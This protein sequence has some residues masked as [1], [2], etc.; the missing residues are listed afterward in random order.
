[1]DNEHNVYPDFVPNQVLTN[2]QL[3]QLRQY[4][5][6][7]NRLGRVRLTGTGIICGLNIHI[8]KNKV[9]I[10]D[11]FGISSEGY[12][13]ELDKAEKASSTFTHWKKYT[14]PNLQ[15]DGAI[16]YKSW[17]KTG[18]NKSQRHI[19]ELVTSPSGAKKITAQQLNGRVLV[20]Y[21]E[22]NNEQLDSCLVTDCD[23]KGVNVHFSIRVL[24][25]K[26]DALQAVKTC[27]SA[28][29]QLIHIPRLH[30]QL[31][32]T[33]V[34][35]PSQINA[36]Y[37]SIVGNM[38]KEVLT[39]LNES[40]NKY[41]AILSM[42]EDISKRLQNLKEVILKAPNQ[43]SWDILNDIADAYNEFISLACKLLDPCVEEQDFPRH[44]MLGALD[45]DAASY[46]QPFSPSRIRN[47]Q[48]NDLERVR[49]LFL[50][51]L[52]LANNID[53]EA[54]D[55]I[56][57]TPSHTKLYPLGKRAL[58][59][60]YTPEVEPYWQP[61]MC[62]TTEDVWSYHFQKKRDAFDYSKASLFRI[63]GHLGENCDDVTKRIR[64]LQKTFNLEFDLL[65]LGIS[66][67]GETESLPSI[68]NDI[69]G[70][71]HTAGVVKGGT[72][73]LLCDDNNTV[74]ADFS[75]TGQ[76]PCCRNF[77]PLELGSIRGQFTDERG[78][79]FVD[80]KVV[81]T[82]PDRSVSEKI[83]DAKAR[84]LFSN[85][86]TGV[87]T[88]Q[89]SI[90]KGQNEDFVSKPTSV[91]IAAGEDKVVNLVGLLVVTQK[92]IIK[93]RVMAEN[94][95]GGLAAPST[96]VPNAQVVLKPGNLKQKSGNKGEFEFK[97]LSPDSYT[98]TAEFTTGAGVIK[99]S[100]DPVTVKLASGETKVA[101]LLFKKTG[102]AT[103]N[104]DIVLINSSTNKPISKAT[105]S[106][107]HDTDT[108]ATA[109][110]NKPTNV[111]TKHFLFSGI[112]PGKYTIKVKDSGFK[113]ASKKST[114]AANKTA[115]A[116][117][118]LTRSFVINNPVIVDPGVVIDIGRPVIDPRRPGGTIHVRSLDT[119]SSADLSAEAV[120]G[121]RLASYQTLFNTLPAAVK[122]SRSAKLVHAFLHNTVVNEPK[123]E[124]ILEKYSALA[125]QI[126]KTLG[127]NRTAV[128]NRG[129]YKTILAAASLALLDSLMMSSPQSLDADAET[130]VRKVKLTLNKAGIP[131]AEFKKQWN[132][133]QLKDELEVSSAS[134]VTAILR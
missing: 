77:Q 82:H 61:H 66:I 88:L 28:K 27:Q 43:Y 98:L 31:P 127:S 59:F 62:C 79:A 113:A 19:L 109:T 104:L 35:K 96:P 6:Q 87:Y 22:Q 14:D 108:S 101:N 78:R 114:V 8:G 75:L 18:N 80:G 85:L 10:S 24:L 20:L 39:R 110:L 5:D 13:I 89:A 45:Q 121:Q 69:P 33:D 34:E 112:K 81:L 64:E 21:L 54:H 103:G 41:A 124:V 123:D 130:A 50:R 63:E 86:Q 122:R 55:G 92:G 26:K 23:S 118:K 42:D 83:T 1:M 111:R 94:I 133:K 57:I 65:P 44:L 70:I 84:Y 134:K 126:L 49:K 128:V 76:V 40:Y 90:N 71:E 53:L 51:I 48:Y 60:Y 2:N 25:V 15:K 107:L 125:S 95:P 46:R 32:L 91:Q 68:A 115:K 97:D 56:A 11:G 47:E 129:H 38:L 36:A 117:I 7:Q 99:R 52:V 120:Y 16:A 3:N 100:T 74:V 67:K 132:A 58:P 72:F 4:L 29:G 30:T 105:V 119:G 102:V 37:Q 73:I 12:L 17:R 106:I 131:L 116:S 9:T 93:G